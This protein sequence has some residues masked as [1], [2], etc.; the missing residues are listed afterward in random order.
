MLLRKNLLGLKLAKEGRKNISQQI[1]KLNEKRVYENNSK[2]Q[3]NSNSK[4]CI[5]FT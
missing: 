3:I 5:K 1:F 4:I 2:R